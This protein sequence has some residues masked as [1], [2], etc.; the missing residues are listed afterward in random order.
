[1]K[2]FI[3]EDSEYRVKYF[4]SKLMNHELTFSSNVQEA[5][6]ILKKQKFDVIFLDHDL[7]FLTYVQSEMPNTGYQLVKF[8]KE[9]N[10]S[11]NKIYA[12]TMNEHGAKNMV[13]L[14]PEIEWIPFF[15]LQMKIGD[16]I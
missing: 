9:N 10:I 13:G 3:L 6:E 16:I 12:H 2:V 5:K 7:D 15:I 14:L 1:M 11:A 8:M 4:K